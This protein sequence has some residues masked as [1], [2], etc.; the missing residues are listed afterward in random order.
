VRGATREIFSFLALIIAY[1]IS[2]RYYLLIAP[3]LQKRISIPW[4]QNAIGFTLIFI[5]IYMCVAI[6][7]WLVSQFIKLIHLKPLDRFAGIFIGLAKGY[8]IACFIIIIVLLTLPQDSSLVET[9]LI[10]K[11]SVP[12]VEKIAQFFPTSFKTIIEERIKE[13]K[14]L[15]PPKIPI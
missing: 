7:G 8:L 2:C 3:L 14:K 9:S 13:L 4:A 10:S 15:V 1:V 12:V 5:I 6:A 11:Y